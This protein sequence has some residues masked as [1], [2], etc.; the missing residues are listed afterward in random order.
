VFGNFWTKAFAETTAQTHSGVA[1]APPVS[2][3]LSRTDALKRGWGRLPL[4][5]RAQKE[6]YLADFALNPA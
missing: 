3:S 6:T 1:L 4:R 5:R 2:L